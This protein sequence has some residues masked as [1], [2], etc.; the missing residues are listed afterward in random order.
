MLRQIFFIILIIVNSV[1]LYSQTDDIKKED[2]NRT[3]PETS[4]VVD[5]NKDKKDINVNENNENL[6]DSNKYFVKNLEIRRL[7]MSKTECFILDSNN[8]KTLGHFSITRETTTRNHFNNTILTDVYYVTDHALEPIAGRAN[9]RDVGFLMVY[10]HKFMASLAGT[11]STSVIDF[12]II[13]GSAALIATSFAL[14]AT[15]CGYDFNNVWGNLFNEKFKDNHYLP[16]F[17]GGV[18]A[19]SYG[20]IFSVVIIFNAIFS[21]RYYKDYV[22]LK[23][24]IIYSLNNAR[25]PVTIKDKDGDPLIKIGFDFRVNFENKLYTF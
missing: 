25:T 16:L 15:D 11:I 4:S 12:V 19:L 13:G 17:I 9:Q 5:E 21:V 18:A 14:F 10:Y 24:S 7:T 1:F 3:K 23:K 6:G 2:E 22:S 8:K 20:V